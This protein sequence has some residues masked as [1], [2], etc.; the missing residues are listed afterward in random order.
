MRAREVEAVVL[1]IAPL[2][3]A[4]EGDANGLLH[5]DPQAEVTGIAVTWTPTVA[6]LRRAATEGLNF[7]FTHE[8]PFFSGGESSWFRTL[9]EDE[10]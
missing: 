8:T 4:I 3:Y 10:R 6:V 5:G 7:I 9:A 1:E 2:E